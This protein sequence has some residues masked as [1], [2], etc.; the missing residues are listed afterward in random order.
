VR[1][2]RC[3]P[4]LPAAELEVSRIADPLISGVVICG[5][6]LRHL[7]YHYPSRHPNAGQDAR[8]EMSK[9]GL[10]TDLA[11][12]ARGG[13]SRHPSSAYPEDFLSLPGTAPESLMRLRS[14]GNPWGRGDEPRNSK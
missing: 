7:F 1:V 12:M 9:L 5:W 11:L 6:G 8:I 10:E 3:R 14:G 13:S 2:R 4:A